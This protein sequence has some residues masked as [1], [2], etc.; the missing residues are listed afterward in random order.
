MARV[1]TRAV[2]ESIHDLIPGL[3]MGDRWA[4]ERGIFCILQSAIPP[5]CVVL[6]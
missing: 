4:G 5:L 3:P 2:P 6:L 1:N